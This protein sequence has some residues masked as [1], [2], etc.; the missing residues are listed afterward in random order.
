LAAADTDS[1]IAELE[2][3]LWRPL[4]KQI[5]APLVTKVGGRK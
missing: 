1:R 4:L 2:A 3:R 5:P